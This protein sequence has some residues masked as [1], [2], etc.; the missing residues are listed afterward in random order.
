[1]RIIKSNKSI[2]VSVHSG[3]VEFVKVNGRV[4]V[5]GRLSMVAWFTWPQF[6]VLA[7]PFTSLSI[8]CS[9]R[10]TLSAKQHRRH[11]RRALVLRLFLFQRPNAGHRWLWPHVSADA[12]WSHGQHRRNHERHLFTR[13][14]DRN[15]L[16][17]FSRP[18]ARI[19][20]SRSIVIGPLNGQPTLMVRVGNQNHHSI[21]E[22][23]FRIMFSCAMSRWLKAAISGI[24]TP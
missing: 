18:V 8:C 6:A 12:V 17:P 4:A 15:D 9:P 11:H 3:Q 13:S 10:F 23:E 1:M 7:A 19:A 14:D 5:A 22:T 16:C 21:V 24:F 20:F 2:P